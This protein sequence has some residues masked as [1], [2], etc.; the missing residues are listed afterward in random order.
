MERG[1][2]EGRRRESRKM[3]GKKEHSL[4]IE[5]VGKNIAQYCKIQN[6]D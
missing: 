4:E 5:R 2:C 6:L 1:I 3:R